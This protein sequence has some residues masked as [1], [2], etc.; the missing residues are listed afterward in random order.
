MTFKP[1]ITRH[2]ENRCL[3][4]PASV[5]QISEND[6]L[7]YKNIE[8]ILFLGD[9]ELPSNIFCNNKL[10]KE[11]IFKGK[12]NFESFNNTFN[13]RITIAFTINNKEISFD[14]L[15]PNEKHLIYINGVPDFEGTTEY[16]RKLFILSKNELLSIL[17]DEM[18]IGI[19]TSF[20]M[21]RVLEQA[22]GQDNRIDELF[23]AS[24]SEILLEYIEANNLVED[25]LF[26]KLHR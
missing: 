15:P 8:K 25:K 18:C 14:F 23:H 17:E 9:V 26:I 22:Y 5:T 4:V 19:Y 7:E 24:Y 1:H 21:L 12:A 13:N 16:I 3:V 6:L 11:V 2:C 10:L 20:F